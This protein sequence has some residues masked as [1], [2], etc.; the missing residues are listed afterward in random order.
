[1]HIVLPRRERRA[2]QTERDKLVEEK[3][4]L[5]KEQDRIADENIKLIAKHLKENTEFRM[6]VAKLESLVQVSYCCIFF[7]K[8]M[9]TDSFPC[10]Y[11]SER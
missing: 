10:W 8:S 7:R 1:M 4:E 5:Q 2:L 9:C 6:Q 3:Q 11:G